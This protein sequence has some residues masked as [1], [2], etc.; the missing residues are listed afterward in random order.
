M[1]AEDNSSII[2]L[3]KF[4]CPAYGAMILVSTCKKRRDIINGTGKF[5]DS[6]AIGKK[7]LKLN[8]QSTSEKC[9]DCKLAKKVDNGTI[10]L[11][12]FFYNADG[13]VYCENVKKEVL[14]NVIDISKKKSK[15][16]TVKLEAEKKAEELRL[17][18]EKKAEELRLAEEEKQNALIK[19]AECGGLFEQDKMAQRLKRDMHSVNISDYCVKC[20]NNRK[21][22]KSSEAS[23]IKNSMVKDLLNGMST[24][25]LKDKPPE[26]IYFKVGLKEDSI[27]YKRIKERARKRKIGV[28]QIIQE[29]I[30]KHFMG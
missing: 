10:E 23:K 12:D 16:N 20:F 7:A 1:L 29:I 28:S 21:N 24:G 30:K 4:E 11:F 13:S 26:T 19:C 9:I 17:A 18:A 2:H 22:A 8:L 27:E 6:G 25:L 15:K 3:K 5:A 14:D